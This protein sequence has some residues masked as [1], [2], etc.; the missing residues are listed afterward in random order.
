MTQTAN[1][2]L[3]GSGLPSAKFGEI[4][5]TVRGTI[6]KIGEPRQ[7]RDMDDNPKV[8]PS[9]DP[10]MQF[11]IELQTDDMDNGANGVV[12]LWVQAGSELQRAL[13][14]AV[15]ASGANEIVEGAQVAVQHSGTTP[16]KLKGGQPKKLYV[17]EYKAPAAK[18]NSVLLNGD[19]SAPSETIASQAGIPAAAQE[20]PSKRPGMLG[21]KST[22]EILAD[23]ATKELLAKLG[24][25]S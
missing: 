21:D 6:R 4:G 3:L 2:I 5:D 11:N 12:N 15:R 25:S 24:L 20:D 19:P 10:V 8:W 16:S 13:A 18:A 1:D 23:P 14:K 9:G 22:E 7:A 17:A